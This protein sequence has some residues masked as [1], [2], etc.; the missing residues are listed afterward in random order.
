MY[1][2]ITPWITLRIYRNVPQFI[3]KPVCVCVC[4]NLYGSVLCLCE[5]PQRGEEEDVSTLD[6]L[7]LCFTKLLLSLST[8]EQGLS[9]GQNTHFHIKK[10]T[11][12]YTRLYKPYLPEQQ[13]Y[14]HRMGCWTP[15][16]AL[17][18]SL[19]LPVTLAHEVVVGFS[20]LAAHKADLLTVILLKRHP[21]TRFWTSQNFKFTSDHIT[22]PLFHH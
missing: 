21:S 9:W 4:V 16:P 18:G 3:L 22:K 12:L 10:R 2:K 20:N 17:P 19:R 6:K 8:S 5:S 13:S 11:Y 1:N 14:T 15:F 7:S